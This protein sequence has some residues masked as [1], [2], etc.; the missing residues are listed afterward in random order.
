MLTLY[1]LMWPIIAA[2]VLVLIVFCFIK[3]FRKAKRE[4][5]KVV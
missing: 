2:A 5:K 4:G 1:I 3:D